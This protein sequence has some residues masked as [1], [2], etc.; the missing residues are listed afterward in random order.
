MRH[1]F[2]F[3]LPAAVLGMISVL[4]LNPVAQAAPSAAQVYDHVRND[5]VRLNMFLRD[6]PKGADLHNHLAGAVYAE[7]MLDWAANA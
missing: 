7:S 3:I 5:P 2:R 4:A 6:F 1:P